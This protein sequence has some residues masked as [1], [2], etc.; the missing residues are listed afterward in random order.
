M[1]SPLIP[2]A[3]SGFPVAR[4]FGSGS[5]NDETRPQ[6]RG[7]VRA[8]R[9]AAGRFG[10]KSSKRTRGC[11]NIDAEVLCNGSGVQGLVAALQARRAR[12]GRGLR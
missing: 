4:V 1:R 6:C 10:R 8:R 12:L 3:K 11:G 9:A 2:K 5:D 7:R